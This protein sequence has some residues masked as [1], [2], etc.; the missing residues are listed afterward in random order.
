MIH[1]DNNYC[2]MP[3]WGCKAKIWGAIALPAPT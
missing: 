1:S 2:I 3:N